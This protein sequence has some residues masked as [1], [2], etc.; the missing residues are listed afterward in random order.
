ML[1]ALRQESGRQLSGVPA[2]SSPAIENASIKIASYE[3]VTQEIRALFN[4]PD[5]GG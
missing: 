2:Q 5:S 3:K 4:S 1:H